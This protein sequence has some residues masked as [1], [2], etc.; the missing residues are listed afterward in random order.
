MQCSGDAAVPCNSNAECA[1]MLGS[2]AVVASKKCS[3]DSE[4]NNVAAGTCSASL[5]RCTQAT[6]I[7]CTT[8]ADCAS[9]AAGPCN[10]STCSTKGQGAAVFPQPNGC[11]DFLCTDL[12]GGEGECTTGP[13]ASFCDAV[14]KAD[15]GGILACFSNED[16]DPA[17]VLIDAGN[18]ELSERAEC[19]LDP[20]TA[21]GDPD[22]ETPI[23]VATF[24]I[25]PTSNGGINSVAGLP[26]P[27]RIVNQATAKTFCESDPNVQYIPG[28]GGCPP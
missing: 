5:K 22:P 11:T 24:C 8:N 19:F 28:V 9:V 12:G 3:L 14:V 16:C 18:C 2:C 1:G 17:N 21:T 15:G 25:P 26:G 6:S 23:G 20:I 13:D 10:P 27:G 4:C 7:V